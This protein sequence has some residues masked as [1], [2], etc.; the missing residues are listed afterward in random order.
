M[1]KWA[2]ELN[3]Q[4]SKEDIRMAKKHMKSCSA[5]LIITEM[6]IKTTMTYHLTPARMVII[7]MSTNSKCWKEM[8]KKEP[9]YTVGGNCKLVQPLWKTGW[10]F[11][12]K[13]KIELPFDPSIPFLGIYLEKTMTQKIHVL[14]C[15]LQHYIQ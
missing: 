9:W 6:Q 1:K 7:K 10:R 8:E 3:R 11:L 2:E 12:K 15:L 5:S 4:L 13:L 14:Q